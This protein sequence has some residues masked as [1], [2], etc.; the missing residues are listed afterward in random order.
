MPSAA[1]LHAWLAVAAAILAAGATVLGL[2]AGLGRI[3]GRG[4]R[5]WM[6]RM[7]LG[8]LAVVGVNQLLGAAV[9]MFAPGGRGP[10]DPLHFV[11]AMVALVALPVVRLE[12]MRRRST[13][14]GWWV[15][16]GGLV[17]LGALLRLWAT[18]G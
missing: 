11:Y 13:R 6:D 5:L 18:G 17:T 14:V 1:V 10:A 2:L 15:C 12:A 4:A 16:A 9:A 3:G 7:V 8:V